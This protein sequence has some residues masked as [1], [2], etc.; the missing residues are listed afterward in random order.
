MMHL[1]YCTNVHPAEDLDGVIA[2]LDQFAGPARSEAELDVVGVGLWL[3][4]ELAHELATNE[5]S[6]DRLRAALERNGLEVRTLNAFPY[7]AFHAEV[8]KL[9][10][11]LPDWTD[12]RRLEYT[13]DAARALAAFLPPRADG[14]ISTLPLGWRTGW[15]PA[16]DEVATAAF[17]ELVAALEQIRDTTGHT[18]R[19][20]IEPEPGCILDNVADI[21]E[22]LGARSD[23]IDPEFVGVCL[24]TCHLAVSFADPTEAVT[25]IESA[26]L[27]VV[28]IQASAAL[29]VLTPADPASREAIAVF[30]EPRY[31]HQVRERHADGILRVDD[32]DEAL[33]TLPGNGPWRVHFHVPLHMVPDA[34]LGATTDVLRTAVDAVVATRPT[35]DVHLDVE[36]YTWSV[37]PEPPADLAAGIASELAWAQRELMGARIE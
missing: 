32:L 4:A 29:E 11:Y 3:P 1:S 26:G 10:V 15:G 16:E 2:Q 9:D 13:I 33:A 19:I 22:W 6:R 8:V 23:V 5:T 35:H 28:K 17:V 20:G 34:P 21:V 18:I 7:A 36:T 12:R 25:A 14:S 27:K 37:L 31:V 24:D 30:G